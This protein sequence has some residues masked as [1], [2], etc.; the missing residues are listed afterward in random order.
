MF[1]VNP[2]RSKLKKTRSME[3]IGEIGMKKA[4]KDITNSKKHGTKN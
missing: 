4:T 3:I 2:I 1:K